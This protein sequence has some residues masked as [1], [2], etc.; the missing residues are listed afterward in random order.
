MV[1][2]ECPECGSREQKVRF[3]TDE[4]VGVV[5]C[6]DC[7]AHIMVVSVLANKNLRTIKDP[8]AGELPDQVFEDLADEGRLPPVYLND[9]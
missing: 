3:D 9:D 5:F 7:D 4:H 8:M 1:C 2:P 6:A